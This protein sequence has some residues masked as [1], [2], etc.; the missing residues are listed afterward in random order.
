M[1]AISKGMKSQYFACLRYLMLL[2]S[3]LY[4]HNCIDLSQIGL[5]GIKL[6]FKRLCLTEGQILHPVQFCTKPCEK[7]KNEY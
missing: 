2:S 3:N 4:G 6:H 5:T 7:K 1:F